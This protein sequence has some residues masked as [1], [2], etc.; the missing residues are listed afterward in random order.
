MKRCVAYD[1]CYGSDAFDCGATT[2]FSNVSWI[3]STRRLWIDWEHEAAIRDIDGTFHE[4]TGSEVY[5]VPKSDIYNNNLCSNDAMGYYS[6]HY[7]VQICQAKLNNLKFK[8]SRLMFNHAVPNSVNGADAVFTNKY[9]TSRALFRDCRIRGLGWMIMLNANSEYEFHFDGFN[10]LTNISYDGDLLNLENDEW[11]TFRHDFSSM[12]DVAKV[13]E[14]PFLDIGLDRGIGVFQNVSLL[15]QE[16]LI[17]P[18][19]PINLHPYDYAVEKSSPP[20]SVRY[21]FNGNQAVTNPELFGYAYTGG[22][23]FGFSPR[24]E[25]CVITSCTDT[26]VDEDILTP[27]LVECNYLDC[28]IIP[29]SNADWYI[30]TNHKVIFDRAALLWSNKHFLMKTLFLDGIIEIPASAFEPGDDIIFEVSNILIGVTNNSTITQNNTEIAKAA[31]VVG[32]AEN[33]I[34]CDAKITIKLNGSPASEVFGSLPGSIPIGSKVLGGTGGI[35]I[36]GCE[37]PI[38]T[39]F[40]RNNGQIG[41]TTITVDDGIDGWKPNDLIV[42]TTTTI[43]QQQ[44]EYHYINNILNNIITLKDP[45]THRHSGSISSKQT[46]LGREF[47]QGAEVALLSR[48]VRIDGGDGGENSFGG[49]LVIA[50]DQATGSKSTQLHS[51]HGQLSFVEFVSMGQLGYSSYTDLRSQVLFYNVESNSPLSPSYSAHKVTSFVNGCSFHHGFNT[52][53]AVMHHSDYMKISNNAV[54]H[55]PGSGIKTNSDF[56]EIL[57]NIVGDIYYPLFFANSALSENVDP[58]TFFVNGRN[59]ESEIKFP[60]DEMPAGIETYDASFVRLSGNCVVGVQGSCYWGSGNPCNTTEPCT[61]GT[62][63]NVDYNYGHA[64]LRGYYAQYQG[65]QLGGNCKILYFFLC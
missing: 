34:P 15:A 13:E 26:S 29:E 20:F 39:T 40:I 21:T 5:I 18:E 52:A 11:I 44:T 41:D 47:Y 45:L 10:H 28:D 17:W 51:A 59:G 43:E 24:F 50:A 8:P 37:V 38:T 9:G 54:F 61:E 55:S 30:P 57:D 2:W 22:R 16:V 27:S 25:A 53:I 49:R 33:P 23:G 6:L 36:F 42:I 19:Q 62:A 63:N 14:I 3:N 7:P 46:V 31:F 35:R 48:N 64:C 56:V 1:P 58:E 32:S 4:H 65:S 12:V 60:D